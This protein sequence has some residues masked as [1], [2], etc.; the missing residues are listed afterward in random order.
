MDDG[1]RERRRGSLIK[2]LREILT[3]ACGGVIF[4]DAFCGFREFLKLLAEGSDVLE[5]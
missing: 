2:S 4:N 1:E 5:E 3:R